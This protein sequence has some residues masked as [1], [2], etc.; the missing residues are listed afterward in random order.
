MVNMWWWNAG[1]SSGSYSSNHTSKCAK[2]A[3]SKQLNNNEIKLML[4]VMN[5]Y[6]KF[7]CLLSTFVDIFHLIN[8]PKLIFRLQISAIPEPQPVPRGNELLHNS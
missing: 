5:K 6:L 8:V 1:I 3:N 2:N 7:Q 4:H